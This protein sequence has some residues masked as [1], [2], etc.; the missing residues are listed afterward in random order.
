MGAK[1]RPANRIYQDE[2]KSCFPFPGAACRAGTAGSLTPIRPPR[3]EVPPRTG[4][5]RPRTHHQI[6]RMK[7][8][9]P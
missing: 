9:T 5:H 8:A 7:E 6:T 1:N 4:R 3:E 2:G